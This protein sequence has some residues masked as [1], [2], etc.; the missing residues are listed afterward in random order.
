MY[1]VDTLDILR[2][3]AGF[4]QARLLRP[5]QVG[6]AR[7][8]DNSRPYA[9]QEIVVTESE[10]KSMLGTPV[11]MPVRV[12]AGSYAQR[13]EKGETTFVQYPEY[14]LPATTIIEVS[15]AKNIIRTQVAGRRGT[16][17]EYISQDDY[18]IRLSGIIVNYENEY[19]PEGDIRIFNE[20]M[21]VP[22]ALEVECEFLQWLGVYDIVV[23]DADILTLKGY[24]HIV[25]F[26]VNAWSDLNPEIRIRDGL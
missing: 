4:G 25:G 8:P 1:K 16:V 22:G 17:K 7:K 10:V 5:Y 15:Q 6:D 18:S 24:S 23:Q 9:D 12:I 11:I 26:R 14:L 3:V 20:V 2:R 21:S 13:N 19:P